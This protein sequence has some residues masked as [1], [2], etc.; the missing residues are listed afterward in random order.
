[1]LALVL[2]LAA[3]AG[4]EA[5]ERDDGLLAY[6]PFDGS[7]AIALGSTSVR[8]V[9][10]ADLSYAEGVSGGA[11]RLV[12]DCRFEIGDGFPVAEGTF[13]GWIRPQFSDSTETPR[14]IF[15]LYGAP[16]LESPWAR[17]RWSL[18]TYGARLSFEVYGDS[19]GRPLTAQG[20]VPDLIKGA[21]HHVAATWSGVNSST[22]G[23]TLR[24]YVDGAPIASAIAPRL[25]VGQTSG[26]FDLGRDSDGSPDYGEMLLDDAFLYARA[27]T[28]EE[29]ATGVAATAPGRVRP[30]PEASVPSGVVPDWD[31][32]GISF[33]CLLEAPAPQ[34]ARR[35]WVLYATPALHE[36]LRDLGLPGVPD[37][38]RARLFARTRAGKWEERT[39]QMDGQ[40][41]FWPVP[42]EWPAGEARG[43]RLYFESLRYSCIA[44]LAVSPPTPVDRAG[45]PGAALPDYAQDEYDDAWDFD[46]GDLEEIDTFGNRPELIRDVRVTEGAMHAKVTRDAYIIWGSMW[47]PEDRGKRRV[48]IDLSQHPVL[49]LRLRQ[50]VPSAIWTIYGRPLGSESLVSHEFPVTG[51]GWQTVRVDLVREA[52]WRGVLSAFRL[53]LTKD[54][55]ADVALDFVRLVRGSEARAGALETRGTRSARAARA[56]II[57]ETQSS[58]AGTEQR[59]RVRV[60]DAAGNPVARQPVRV[61]IKGESAGAELRR[62]GTPSLALGAASRRALTG[63][64]GEAEFRLHVGRVAERSTKVFAEAEFAEAA[65]AS[66]EVAVRAGEASRYAV[67]APGVMIVPEEKTPLGLRV[68]A[69][70]GCGNPVPLPERTISWRIEEARGSEGSVVATEEGAE[71]ALAPDMTRRWV[72]RVRVK[73]ERGLEGESGDICVLPKGPPAGKI[74]L[75]SGGFQTPDGQPFVPLGGFYAVWIPGIP[76]DGDEEGRRLRAFTEATEDEMRHWFEFLRSQ[77][78]TALR[79]ML[80]THRPGGTEA[81]D[82]GGRVNRKLFARVLRLIDLARQHDLRFMLTLHDDYEKPV[83]VN[84]RHL[85][86]FALPAFAGEDLGA[87]PPYQRRFLLERDLVSPRERYLD[88]D[89]IACQDQYAR[90]IVGYLKDNPALLAWELENEM[91]DC[92]V[93]W[94]NHAVETIRSVDPA[95]PVCI[96]HGG[97]GLV[98]ADPLYWTRTKVDFYTYHLYPL[99]VTSSGIDYGLVTDVL[100]RY[101]RMAGTCFLGESSGDEFNDYPAERDGERRWIMRDLIWLSLVNRN[102]GCFFWNARGSEIA[103]FRFA[104]E[105][106]RDASWLLAERPPAPVAVRVAHPLDTDT[107]YRTAAGRRDLAMMARYSRHFLERGVEFDF[108]AGGA[109]GGRERSC[110]LANFVPPE[111]TGRFTPTSGFQVAS[112]T[113]QDGL[114]GLL[115]VRCVSGI[116]SWNPKEDRE[117]WLRQRAPAPLRLA[118]WKPDG[119]RAA[120]R[121]LDTGEERTLA[122]GAG[123]VLDLGVTDH[124][125]AVLWELR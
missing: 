91:V 88:P 75:R 34:Q 27:L 94:V 109:A 125:F 43:F 104:A 72:Y 122:P 18:L 40:T 121:D 115:Y 57:P 65:K 81:M 3:L 123:G 119:L 68:T 102:P 49:V 50:S 17:N 35:D 74:A 55:E 12:S 79:M 120:V 70:D 76:A 63:S 9:P 2:T 44:P 11:L 78:V 52:R 19:S 56:A 46:E 110:D 36:G 48:R 4:S 114:A 90:E 67:G 59:L 96:S 13:A 84:E 77:G 51:T 14:Y 106:L 87:L 113:R 42:G 98:T 6:L 26:Q 89:A 29:I 10:A 101:G 61:W 25:D 92:P 58:V 7:A 97:G 93:S 8:T 107:W 39:S 32:P 80:R 64:T 82:V 37:L 83:Y 108:V 103:E 60:E 21:W 20:S 95:T 73:D 53:N 28:A 45:G 16:R 24:L 124:D 30:A 38:A 118:C 99:G 105:V 1:M 22:G 31:A 117:M 100:T 112:A 41:L 15:C 33:R 86:S 47:G 66:I 85:A 62:G 23:A 116:R 111:V 54:V 69:T 5:A 71:I